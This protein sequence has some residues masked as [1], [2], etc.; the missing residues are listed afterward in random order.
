MKRNNAFFD[1]EM[2]LFVTTEEKTEALYALAQ[3][4]TSRGY[5]KP[6]YSEGILT[7]EHVYPTGLFTGGINV[8]VPHTDCRHVIKDGIA[9]GILSKPILFQA[10]DEPTQEIPVRIIV[11]LALK[12][13]HGQ[14][15]MLQAVISMIQDQETL[16]KL[17]NIHSQQEAYEILQAFLVKGVYNK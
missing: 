5:V 3:Q 11:M 2:I 10:M 15:A 7:R 17:L 6:S 1:E 16:K 8:A 13:P 14:L 9:V 4:L 12:E